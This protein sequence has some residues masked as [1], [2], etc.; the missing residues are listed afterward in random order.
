[1]PGVTS[2]SFSIATLAANRSGI[3]VRAGVTSSGRVTVY[4]SKAVTTDV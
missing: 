4:L 3:Y 1:V 2:A